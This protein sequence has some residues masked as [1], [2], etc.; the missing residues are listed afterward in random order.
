M[1]SKKLL[2]TRLRKAWTTVQDLY[3]SG[4]FAVYPGTQTAL[5]SAVSYMAKA[6]QVFQTEEPRL[7]PIPAVPTH[8]D[9]S[10]PQNSQ[11]GGSRS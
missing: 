11:E 4:A 10:E 3:M 7:F 6:S 8:E 1:A 9:G 5:G 2:N